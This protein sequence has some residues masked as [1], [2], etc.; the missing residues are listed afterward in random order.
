MKAARASVRSGGG[1]FGAVIVKNGRVVGKG[2][3]RV[4]RDLDPTAHAEVRA[5]RDACR[6]LKTFS[7]AGCALYSSCE[8]CPMCLAAALWS[9]LDHVHFAATRHD[10]ARAGFDDAVFHKTVSIKP[11]KGFLTQTPTP[12]ATSPFTLWRAKADKTPY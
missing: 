4:T 6:R 7:L 3:N 1:P 9:R 12:A 5:I 10:A 8:P 2:N 11:T